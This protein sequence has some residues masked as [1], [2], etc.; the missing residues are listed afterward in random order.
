[1]VSKVV[2]SVNIVYKNGDDDILQ[3]IKTSGD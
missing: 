3:D 1:M 2:D